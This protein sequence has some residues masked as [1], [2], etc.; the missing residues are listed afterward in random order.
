MKHVDRT[1]LKITP[2]LSTVVQH[3][4]DEKICTDKSS[5]RL[6]TFVPPVDLAILCLCGY[7]VGTEMRRGWRPSC[8]LLRST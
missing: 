6:P 8:S 4:T 7:S 3:N 2:Y 1:P 5:R